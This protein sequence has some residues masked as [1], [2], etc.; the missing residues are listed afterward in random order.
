MVQTVAGGMKTLVER[1]PL[2]KM[3]ERC[4]EKRIVLVFALLL[5][6]RH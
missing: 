2:G 6:E 3:G 1:A 5:A 4:V